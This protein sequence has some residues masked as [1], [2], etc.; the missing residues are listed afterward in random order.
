MKPRGK[1]TVEGWQRE[2]GGVV[3]LSEL[4]LADD[5]IV[6]RVVQVRIDPPR[7]RGFVGS[8]FVCEDSTLS[9]CM[10]STEEGARLLCTRILRELER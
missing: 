8:H 6:L 3:G 4:W 5:Q 1:D 7:F 9:G 10:R 2:P